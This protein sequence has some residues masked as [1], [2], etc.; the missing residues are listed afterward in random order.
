MGETIREQYL[1][2]VSVAER[3]WKNLSGMIPYFQSGT[4]TYGDIG[5][6]RQAWDWLY[7]VYRVVSCSRGLPS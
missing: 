1:S 4:N 3:K 6:I 5:S 2:A 7:M